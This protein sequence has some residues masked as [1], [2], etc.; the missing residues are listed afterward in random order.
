MILDV[1]QVVDHVIEVR[2]VLVC[3]QDVVAQQDLQPGQ[4][5]GCTEV[6][7]SQ[8]KYIGNG[9]KLFSV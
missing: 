6:S 3:L 9:K 2:Q 7:P 4:D 1:W 8:L 5:H